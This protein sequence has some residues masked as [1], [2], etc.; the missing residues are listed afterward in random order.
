MGPSLGTPEPAPVLPPAV[1]IRLYPGLPVDRDRPVPNPRPLRQDDFRRRWRGGERLRD[2][3]P[4]T[5][6]RRP[7]APCVN[8]DFRRH[9]FFRCGTDSVRV[10][11]LGPRPSC[12]VADV[13]GVERVGNAVR[14]WNEFSFVTISPALMAYFQQRFNQPIHSWWWRPRYS[15][16][17]FLIHNVVSMGVAIGAESLFKHL[18]ASSSWARSFFSSAA[19]NVLGPSVLTTVVGAVQVSHLSPWGRVWLNVS[20]G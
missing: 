7:F 11:V 13:W 14:R 18:V 17:T 15:Y 16:A 4:P 9:T 20:Q 12:I 6:R 5:G 8:L 1:H 10:R 19:W 3:Q 2:T